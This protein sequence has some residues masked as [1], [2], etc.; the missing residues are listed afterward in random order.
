MRYLG[1]LVRLS[2]FLTVSMC[3]LGQSASPI[4]GTVLSKDGQP[5]A[6]VT[7]MGSAWKECCP[8]QYEHASTDEKGEF[9]LEHPVP[10]IYLGK[11]GLQPLAVVISGRT[12]LHISMEPEANSFVIRPC[13]PPKRGE[14][15]IPRSKFGLNFSVPEHA[16]KILGGKPDVDYVE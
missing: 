1:K 16:G 7:V 12:S 6:G 10:V 2:A 13:E 14:R 5:L 4:H 15:Q 9:T 3:A 8:V 11:D